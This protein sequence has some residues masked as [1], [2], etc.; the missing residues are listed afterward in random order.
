MNESLVFFELRCEHQHN[1][2]RVLKAAVKFAEDIFWRRFCFSFG[3]VLGVRST[4]YIRCV[5]TTYMDKNL[6]SCGIFIDLQ[7]AF[8]TIDHEILLYK[9]NHYGIRGI[10]NNWFNSYLTGRY[11]TTQIGTKFSKKERVICGVTQ[12]SVLGPL[13][14]LL[15]I[16]DIQTSSAKFDFFLFADNTNLLFAEKSLKSLETVVNKELE[17]VCDWLL[18]NKLTLN[19]KKSNYVIFHPHR[20]NDWN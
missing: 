12:G 20:K 6:F 19:I 3:D 18:A 9:L 14:F 1:S 17:C 8:D 16:N 13:L 2:P 11:Q 5:K 4:F 10:A 7:K 15:Y